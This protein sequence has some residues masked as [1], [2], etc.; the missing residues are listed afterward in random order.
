MKRIT[1]PV[2]DSGNARIQIPADCVNALTFGSADCLGVNWKR[3][4][5]S[6]IG[7]GRSPG[8]V[9]PDLLSFGGSPKNPFYVIGAKGTA[10]GRLGT[11]FALPAG[12]R[13]AIGVRAHLGP[14]LTPLALKTLLIHRS[15]QSEDH[16]HEVG[17]GKVAESIDDLI[18]CDDS[19][20]SIVYQGSLTP[21]SWMR[22]PI[23]VPDTPI[24]GMLELVATICFVTD[25][26][27]QD[28]IHYTRSGLEIR[29][30]PHDDKKKEEKQ[31]EANAKPFFSPGKLY[32]EEQLR[33]DAHKWETTLHTAGRMRGSSLQN[34]SFDIHYNARE[35]GGKAGKPQ[36]IQYALIVTIR[37]P[38]SKDLYDRIFRRYRTQLEALR[39]V[40]EIPVRGSLK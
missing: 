14:V 34:P 32:A 10:E 26:D 21:G 4:A 37:A 9:K 12:L 31:K 18:H 27:P 6:S 38:K 17:W 16:Q 1:T 28:P 13:A 30:R 33:A 29:F 5:H 11:S 25:T 3:S 22:A 15:Y 24:K 8:V 23:P 19:T 35:G 2:H 40:I 39:P 36:D 20:A 7:P